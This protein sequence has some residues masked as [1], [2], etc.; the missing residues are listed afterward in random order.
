M[1]TKDTWT[2]EERGERQEGNQEENKEASVQLGKA[3]K[4][5]VMMNLYASFGVSSVR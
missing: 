3:Q 5:K 4:C 2:W 1:S